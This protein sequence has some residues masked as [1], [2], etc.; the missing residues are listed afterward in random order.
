MPNLKTRLSAVMLE[1]RYTRSKECLEEIAELIR[2]LDDPDSLLRRGE[3]PVRVGEEFLRQHQAKQRGAR[4]EERRAGDSVQ[5]RDEIDQPR[6]GAVV[7]E[8]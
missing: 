2:Q 6:V 1:Y 8:K 7:D 5:K 3:D 4:R